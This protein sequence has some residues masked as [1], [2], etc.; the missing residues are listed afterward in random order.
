MHKQ[1]ADV[2]ASADALKFFDWAFKKEAAKM[3]EDLIYIPMPDAVVVLIKKTWA[4][5]LKDAEGKPLFAAD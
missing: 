4:T 3:A 2:A 5:E 1:A